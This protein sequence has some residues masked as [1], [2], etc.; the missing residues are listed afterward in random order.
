M[1]TSSTIS[2]RREFAWF[3]IDNQYF[4]NT[5]NLQLTRCGIYWNQIEQ[6]SIR[7]AL[8]T[9]TEIN[10]GPTSDNYAVSDLLGW[11]SSYRKLIKTYEFRYPRLHDRYTA[12]YPYPLLT[13][14][15]FENSVYRAPPF[16]SNLNT[17]LTRLNLISP[18][19]PRFRI[20]PLGFRNGR[21]R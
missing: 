6:M 11:L 1:T 14:F 3:H 21:D 15:V 19:P 5:Y 9:E 12:N 20:F 13:F 2:P 8:Y 4:L 7:C 17:A 18:I 16:K 10:I